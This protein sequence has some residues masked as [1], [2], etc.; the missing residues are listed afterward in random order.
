MKW[1]FVI[2]YFGLFEFN[3]YSIQTM[4]KIFGTFKIC[5]GI[6]HFPLVVFCNILPFLIAIL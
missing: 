5:Q 1:I 6:P 3:N 4:V 2:F